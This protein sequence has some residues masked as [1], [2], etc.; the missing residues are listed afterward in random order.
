[1]RWF[2]GVVLAASLCGLP[3]RA[4]AQ[5]VASL[6]AN[7]A[8]ATYDTY[9]PSAVYTLAPSV[10]YANQ[11]FRL[12]LDGAFAEFQTGH[13]SGILAP[14]AAIGGPIYDGLRWEFGGE[15]AALWYRTSP[16]V[17][18]GV[19]TPRI[20]YDDGPLDAWVGGA[21]GS[22]DNDSVF[23]QFVARGDVGV[24]LTLPHVTPTL[25]LSDTRAGVAHFTDAAAAVQSEWGRLSATV[26]GG[27]RSGALLGGVA[28]W[29]N[30]EA[31]VTVMSG[32]AL[33]LAG[34]SYPADPVRGAPGA[35]FIGGGVRLSEAFRLGKRPPPVGYDALYGVTDIM[36]DAR[37]LRFTAR[38][39]AHVEL[40]ADFT[41]WQ[42]VAMVE[43]KPGL[44]QVT[45]KDVVT[46]GPHRV[47]IRVDD[48]QWSVPRELPPVTDD[49][50]GTAGSLVVP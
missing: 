50:G 42:P 31:R 47:N 20:R 25:T 3:C 36:P 29:F 19:L 33:E 16:P 13:G 34:G 26:T 43:I 44:Y 7:A 41:A 14:S 24:S 23:G 12:G 38:A 32:V 5:I 2:S 45:L 17:W 27:T 4:A 22:T 40:M 18:S 46:S 8:S 11:R 10:A 6:D 49:F 35:H 28:S 39:S 37:T 15:A 30:A 21:V 48:G 9:L 1:V